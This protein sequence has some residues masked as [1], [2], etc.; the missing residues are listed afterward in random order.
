MN[1]VSVLRTRTVNSRAY[2][3]ESQTQDDAGCE[4]GPISLLSVLERENI[5]LRQAVVA[6]LIDTLTLREALHGR[7]VSAPWR[8]L[9]AK[10][11]ARNR[12]HRAGDKD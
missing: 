4:C 10:R 2:D 5:R 11:S 7:E 6:L 12:R 9:Q 3:R 1:A 8:G